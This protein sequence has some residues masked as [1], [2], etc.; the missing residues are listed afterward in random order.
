VA[1]SRAALGTEVRD[2]Y[3]QTEHG[4]LIVNGWHDDVRTEVR[5]GSMGRPLPGYSCAVLDNDRDK[6][7]PAGTPGRIAVDITASPLVYFTQY[8]GDTDPA[9]RFTPGGRWWLTG[10]AGLTGLTGATSPPDTC[11]RPTLTTWPSAHKDLPVWRW[12]PQRLTGQPPIPADSAPR[13]AGSANC[14]R[15]ELTPAPRPGSP[16]Q[17]GSFRCFE[18]VTA[19]RMASSGFLSGHRWPGGRAARAER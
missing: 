10:D 7:A 14:S 6:P 12:R 8:H 1:W 19:S 17:C 18:W 9:G 5:P 16:T 4:M 3:G 11:C 15:D 2:H 13:A